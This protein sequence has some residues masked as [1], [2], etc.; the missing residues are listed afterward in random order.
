MYN[1]QPAG[2]LVPGASRNLAM[3]RIGDTRWHRELARNYRG[4]ADHIHSAKK[5]DYTASLVHDNLS[6]ALD[7]SVFLSD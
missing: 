3:S 5:R 6:A 7:S 2:L 1:G 4:V